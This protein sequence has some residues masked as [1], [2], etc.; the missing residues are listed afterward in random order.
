[1]EQAV[2][3]R[4]CSAASERP[5]GRTTAELLGQALAMVGTELAEVRLRASEL[6]SEPT[7]AASAAA[8]HLLGSG[9]KGVRPLLALLAARSVGG[10]AE[11][12]IPHAVAAELV[13]SASLLHDD[14]ID[15]GQTRRGRPCPR[16]LWGNTISVLS[17]DLLFLQA[18]RLIE[19]AGPP[20]ILR[21]AMQTVCDLV[22][23]EVLQFEQK[24]RFATDLATYD[25]IVERKTASLFRWC[26]RAGA[27]AGG[28][29]GARVDA[30]GRFG[31]HVGIA[32]QVRD[33]VLDLTGD[34]SAMG[35]SFAADLVEGKLTLP[36]IH[37][38]AAR[39]ALV[40]VL[41]RVAAAGP[42]ADPIDLD[43]VCSTVVE[44][45]GVSAA[46]NRMHAELDLALAA[47]DEIGERPEIEVLRSVAAALGERAR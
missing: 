19:R 4:L 31:F 32:F 41:Q 1:M 10:K 27:V 47:L 5:E 22:E 33:D 21:E 39:P 26:A 46:R 2:L 43:Q 35:K 45:G 16:V 15:D 36:V 23:G 44:A 42:K 20:E 14:V 18:L 11:R 28:A 40:D 13:H 7:P 9:G 3:S 25:S 8:L 34:P 12:A 6:A 29:A 38:L 24:G 30:L 17:G 37:A